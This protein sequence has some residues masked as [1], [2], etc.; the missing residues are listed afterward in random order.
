MAGGPWGP[1]QRHSVPI[2]GWYVGGDRAS[3]TAGDQGRP[4]A[5]MDDPRRIV[6]VNGDK[7]SLVC[8]VLVLQ[9]DDF[10]GRDVHGVAPI[11]EGL[12]GGVRERRLLCGAGN[13]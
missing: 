7:Y 10:G 4:A 2:V 5:V 13:C 8:A 12:L 9:S 6:R 11:S 3:G 1:P